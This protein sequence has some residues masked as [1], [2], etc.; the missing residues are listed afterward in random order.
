MCC[1]YG[2]SSFEKFEILIVTSILSFTSSIFEIWVGAGWTVYPPLTSRIG[3]AGRS[4]DFDIFPLHLTGVS[5]FIGSINFIST[6]I[7]IWSP[8]IR[9]EK[10]LHLYDLY[11][12]QLFYYYFFIYMC[13]C[14]SIYAMSRRNV[15]PESN[16][17]YS[18]NN[19]FIIVAM[20]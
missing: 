19:R 9:I 10:I 12:L 20:G 6:N 14:V 13:I 18:V 15:Q 7:N 16:R 3:H 2:F 4:V 11:W 5:S 1:W 17:C 8:G